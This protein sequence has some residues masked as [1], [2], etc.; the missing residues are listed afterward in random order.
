M[1]QE[2]LA[3][4][5]MPVGWLSKPEIRR[6]AQEAGFPNADKPDS[7]EICFIPLGDY[8]KFLQDRIATKPG[9]L[10]D[11]QGRVLGQHRGIEFF[12]IGQRKGLGVASTQPLF[13]TAIDPD[14]GDVTLGPEDTL[15]QTELWAEQVNYVAG[16]APDAGTEVTV[17]IRYK[18]AETPASLYPKHGGVLARFDQPQ[19]AV[20]PGQAVVFY[21]G[22][23]VIGGGRIG[24]LPSREAPQPSA[25]YAVP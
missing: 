14:T 19:R 10:V 7:Q 21:R 13:V 6:L 25:A 12:T 23:E 5:L 8:R 1:G 17:K 9:N 3:S 4:T 16:Q 20:T 2:Q 22:D 24:R 11:G 15:M 18:S